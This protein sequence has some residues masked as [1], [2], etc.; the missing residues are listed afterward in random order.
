MIW[1]AVPLWLF[2]LAFLTGFWLATFPNLTEYPP[3]SLADIGIVIVIFYLVLAVTA[4][5][6]VLAVAATGALLAL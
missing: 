1:L 3:D 4:I 5:A 6:L 2:V